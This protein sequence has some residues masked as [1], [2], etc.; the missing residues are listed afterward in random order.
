MASKKNILTLLVTGA[1]GQ[2]G[3]SLQAIA[4]TVRHKFIF[5]DVEDLDITSSEAVAA[6]IE[7][8]KPNWVINCA[9]YTA[10]DKAESDVEAATLLNTTAVGILSEETKK[11]NVGLVHISTDYVF[12]GDNPTPLK[13]DE[14][15]APKSVYGKTK[16]EGEKLAV[17]NPQHIVIRTSWLYSPYGKNFVKTMQTLGAKQSEISVVSD[18]WGSPTS[19]ADLAKAIIVAVEKPK[20][21]VYHFA[22]EGATSWALF[23]EEIMLLSG[24][25]CVVNH[26]ATS[27][28]PTPAARPEYSLLDKHK[29][30]STFSVTIPEWEAALEDMIQQQRILEAKGEF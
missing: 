8:E 22:G 6:I 26:I 2:L 25:E 16:L 20:F 5:T 30:A 27:E 17:L 9:A 29:F 13:E 7:K 24:I 14:P 10:V 4:P 21:G 1:N 11:A 28:Y 19:A 15:T 18:Q 23:A 3:R 12:G